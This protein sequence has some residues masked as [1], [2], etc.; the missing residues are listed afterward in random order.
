MTLLPIID[1]MYDWGTKRMDAI[2]QKIHFYGKE[3]TGTKKQSI[4]IG[5]TT[6]NCTHH[7]Y[8]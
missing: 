8:C 3:K 1:T 6:W 4:Q 2:K 7:F 5:D